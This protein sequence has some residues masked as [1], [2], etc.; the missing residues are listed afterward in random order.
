MPENHADKTTD[1][2]TAAARRAHTH[3]GACGDSLAQS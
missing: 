3:A 1:Y 2:H